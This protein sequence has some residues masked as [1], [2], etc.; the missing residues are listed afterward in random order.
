MLNA[1]VTGKVIPL[2][3]YVVTREALIA[4]ASEFDPQPF[5]LDEAAATSSVLAGLATSGWHTSSILMRLICDA[6]FLR[7]ETVGSA[8]IDEMKWLKPVYA[9]D[10]LSGQ[11]TI[12]AVRRSISKA[13]RMIVN[14][15]AE[16]WDQNR[17]PKA[18]MRS[19]VF[20]AVPT[21]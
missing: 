9:N 14:F 4:F 7:V 1:L 3:P 10:T 5:H 17:T 16:L 18:S 21:P 6:F 15:E 2:G 13:D 8:G 11:L 20:I 19:M 12:T